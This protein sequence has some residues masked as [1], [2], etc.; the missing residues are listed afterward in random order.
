MVRENPEFRNAP[1]HADEILRDI[2]CLFGW[3]SMREF[4]SKMIENFCTQNSS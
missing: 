2:R 4:R 3:S 1:F